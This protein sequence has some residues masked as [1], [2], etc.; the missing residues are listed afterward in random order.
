LRH[1]KIT[2]GVISEDAIGVL[3][4]KKAGWVSPTGRFVV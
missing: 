3:H 2:L 1:R 4:K